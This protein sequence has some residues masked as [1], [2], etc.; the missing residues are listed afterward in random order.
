[1]TEELLTKFTMVLG[2]AKIEYEGTSEFL[3][4]EIMPTV[5]KIVLMASTQTELHKP[6]SAPIF[7][8]A[9]ISSGTFDGVTESADKKN[10]VSLAAF[11]KRYKAESNQVQRFLATA[12]WLQLRGNT[13]L[14]SGDVAKALQENQQSKLSNPSDCLN[15]NVAKGYCEKTAHSFFITPEGLS[16]LGKSNA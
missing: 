6:A 16:H 10:S 1:M 11:L 7:E 3:K 2:G 13:E 9:K 12:N 15:K 14:K 8:P 4:N 5:E